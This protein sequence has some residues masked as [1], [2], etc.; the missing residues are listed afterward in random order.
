M[1]VDSILRDQP[2]AALLRL[3]RRGPVISRNTHRK[4]ADQ[5]KPQPSTSATVNQKTASKRQFP[6]LAPRHLPVVPQAM[7]ESARPIESAARPDPDLPAESVA[8][9]APVAPRGPVLQQVRC[10]GRVR[11]ETRE[12]AEL[13]PPIRLAQPSQ[14]QSTEPSRFFHFCETSAP[15]ETQR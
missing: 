4:L 8:L 7:I 6:P 11:F 14:L 1:A 10:R 5:A 15:Q 13:R 12:S 3:V 9:D 2:A